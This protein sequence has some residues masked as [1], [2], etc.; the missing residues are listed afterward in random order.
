MLVIDSLWVLRFWKEGVKIR[1]N[2][3][4]FVRGYNGGEGVV[5]VGNN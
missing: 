2:G 5:V 3:E 1:R 4:K